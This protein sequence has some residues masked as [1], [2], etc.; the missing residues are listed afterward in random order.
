MANRLHSKLLS[1]DLLKR[2]WHLARNDSRA[3]FIYDAYR[4]ND[5]AFRLEENLKGLLLK[6]EAGTYRPQPILEI[7]V[8]KSNLAVRPGSVVEIED[9]IV[10]FAILCLIAPILDKKLPPTVYSNRLK[11]KSDKENLFKDTEILDF[12]FLK[13]TTIQT[14][15]QIFEP[16]YG[17]WPQFIEQSQYT[18]QKEGYNFLSIADISAYFENINLE[19]LRDILLRYLPKEQRIVNML[20]SIYEDWVLKTPDGR[21]VGRGI[22]QGNSASSFLANIYLLPLDEAFT[23]TL[24][25]FRVVTVQ[26]W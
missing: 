11:D 12:P 2:A 10:L 26:A 17:Q 23:L 24:H 18:F 25:K 7:D 3:D 14:R 1:L 16:W 20:M 5:Y 22:P 19:I 15:L 21:S 9:R 6:L 4:Y 8:P 13:K